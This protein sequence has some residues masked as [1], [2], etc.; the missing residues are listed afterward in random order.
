MIKGH[1]PYAGLRELMVE[2]QIKARGISNPDVLQAMNIVPR[3]EFLDQSY[4]TT[5]YSDQ[6]IPIGCGQAVSKPYTVALMADVLS[7]KPSDRVL[8]IG[9]GCGYAAAV[10]SHLCAYVLSIEMVDQLAN[11]SKETFTSVNH[12]CVIDVQHANA[13]EL[14]P[15]EL[16]DAI[17]VTC[18]YPKVP[19][20][21]LSFLRTGGR[22]VMPI[23]DA[24]G[25][26][27]LKLIHKLEDGN[28]ISRDIC[29]VNFVPLKTIAA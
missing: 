17:S 14:D 22:M 8:E 21:F 18:A 10:L 2:Q 27:V 5:A 13:L 7:L 24:D 19:E 6:I 11:H 4:W 20:R 12:G 3:H 29:R 1:D 16:F 25:P 28:Y 15:I 23:G 9:C 26:Q